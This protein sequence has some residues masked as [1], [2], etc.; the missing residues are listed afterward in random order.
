ML[1]RLAS[2]AGRQAIWGLLALGFA[3]WEPAGAAEVVLRVDGLA[4]PFCAFGIEKKLLE[5]PAVGAIDIRMD[6]GEVRLV[7]REGQRLDVATLAAAVDKAGF[8]LRRIR[9]RDAV[10]TLRLDDSE[11]LILECSDPPARFRLR[12]SGEDAPAPTEPGRRVSAGGWVE[13]FDG[14]PP[15]LHVLSLRP[16]GDDGAGL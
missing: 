13:R 10:G 2:R 7:L 6:A 5:V 9:I 14:N 12:L 1:R 16:A 8:T 11:G 15:E 3:G 4:C